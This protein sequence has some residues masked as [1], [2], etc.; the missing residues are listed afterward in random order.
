M[1][2]RPDPSAADVVSKDSA[3][4]IKVWDPVVRLFHWTVVSG[5]LVNLI[6]EDGDAVHR[7][8]GYLVAAAI[9]IRLIWG[10]VAR[11]HARFSSFVPGPSTLRSYAG[12]MLRRREP[13]YVGHNPAG[14]VM[15]MALVGLLIGVSLTG[16][17]MGFDR[18]WGNEMLQEA[19]ELIANAILVLAVIHVLAALFESRRH[20]ENLIKAMITGYKRKPRGTDIDNATDPG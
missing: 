11:G 16:W 17:L 2:A 13:R 4:R 8:L 15:M 7:W 18:F 19:H 10:F 3:G 6:R 1:N 20:H 5:C 12:Q 14:A 9:A